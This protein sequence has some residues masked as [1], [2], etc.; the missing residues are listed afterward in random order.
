MVLLVGLCTLT[1][2]LMKWMFEVYGMFVIVCCVEVFVEC[3]GG[4]ETIHYM[5]VRR[6]FIHCHAVKS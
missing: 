6:E 3:T 2:Y 1:L 4:G 5:V